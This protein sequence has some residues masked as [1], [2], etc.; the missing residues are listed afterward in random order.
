MFNS[1]SPVPGGGFVAT[2]PTVFD[3]ENPPDRTADGEVAMRGVIYEWHPTDGWAVVPGSE[4]P[5][6]NGVKASRDGEW[7]YVNLWAARQV[8]RLSR[9]RDPVEKQIVDVGF[10][11]DNIRWQADGTLLTAGHEAKSAARVVECLETFCDDMSS[12]VARV[13]PETLMV[14]SLVDVPANPNFFSSTAAVQVG[15]EIWVASTRGERIARYP[16]LTR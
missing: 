10:Q 11:P 13:D 14:E 7:L 15:D 4:S 6:P 12:H 1:V 3:A 5:V 2:V 9:G 8:M 16:A